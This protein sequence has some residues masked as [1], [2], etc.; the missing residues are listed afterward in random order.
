VLRLDGGGATARA[1]ALRAA[2]IAQLPSLGVRGLLE[3]RGRKAT[4]EV[5]EAWGE[6]APEEL[7]IRERGMRLLVDP[8]R[9][10]KTGMFLDHRESRALVRSLSADARVLNL[11]GY[12]GG[13]SIAAGLG[14]ARLVDTVDV[15]PAAV[16]T[17]VRAWA[18]NGLEPRRHTGHAAD[19][20]EFLAA[21]GAARWELIVADPP[22][23]AP[24]A[25]AVPAALAS[26]R[27]LHAACLRHLTR[28]GLY[29]A[30]SCSSHVDREAF[31]RTLREGAEDA[32]AVLQVLGRWGAPAD[33]PRLAAF[34]EGDYLKV[35][36][37]RAL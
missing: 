30:A 22:S 15:A 25:A 37:A 28:G 11:Y 18:R 35:V 17:A 14:G 33:H 1:E 36:L 3:R 16:D 34:P 20:P 21:A 10:Q 23:F 2:L 12:T 4:L 19:V 9:G 13:F 8:W 7:E 29:V 26:Y 24:K 5:R 31:E 27:K 6:R 32:G